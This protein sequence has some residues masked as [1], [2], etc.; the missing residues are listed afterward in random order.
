MKFEEQIAAHSRERD[1]RP[2][3]IR[4]ALTFA[5]LDYCNRR[6][7]RAN[8]NVALVPNVNLAT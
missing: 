8:T 6:C 3:S 2:S 4:R 1:C 5:A 7:K